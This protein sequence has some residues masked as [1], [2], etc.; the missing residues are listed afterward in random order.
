M[1]FMG[2]KIRTFQPS[3]VDKIPEEWFLSF[4]DLNKP[5]IKNYMDEEYRKKA[6]Q[7][8]VMN[9]VKEHKSN[10]RDYNDPQVRKEINEQTTSEQIKKAR[11]YAMSKEKNIQ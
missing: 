4:Q 7:T 9:M 10:I 2:H 11:E 6:Q 1:S 8:M 3:T 5:E